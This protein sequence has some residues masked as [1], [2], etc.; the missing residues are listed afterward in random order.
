MSQAKAIKES[1]GEAGGSFKVKEI[2]AVMPV[3]KFGAQMQ[4]KSASG[5]TK[6]MTID[7]DLL[8]A[9]AKNGNKLKAGK[10]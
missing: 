9:I 1:L 5:Q 7:D 3:D 10:E 6:W 4:I 8:K 2:Q